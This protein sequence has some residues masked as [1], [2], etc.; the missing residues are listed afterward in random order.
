MKKDLRL[1]DEFGLTF[2]IVTIFISC[3]DVSSYSRRIP[4]EACP[5]GLQNA[6]VQRSRGKSG[7]EPQ[8]DP[9]IAKTLNS[10]Q[11]I[12]APKTIWTLRPNHVLC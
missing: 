4:S 3:N 9:G 7:F 6:R 1:I 10:A 11:R 8:F 12:A 2:E 5:R